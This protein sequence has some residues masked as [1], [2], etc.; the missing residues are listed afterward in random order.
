MPLPGVRPT[1]RNLGFGLGYELVEDLRRLALGDSG[2][3]LG[4]SELPLE[5]AGLPLD[6]AQWL[7]SGALGIFSV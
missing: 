3:P 1:Q 5:D 2:L 7:V 6:G 4:D